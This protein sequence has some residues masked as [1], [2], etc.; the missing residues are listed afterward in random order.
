LR[1]ETDRHARAR[2]QGPDVEVHFLQGHQPRHGPDEHEKGVAAK[3]LDSLGALFQFVFVASAPFEHHFHYVPAQGARGEVSEHQDRDEL[4]CGA[5]THACRIHTRV[6][7]RS[8][9][10]GN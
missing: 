1:A 6:N 8:L 5:R 9:T 10:I 2:Q 4:H 3:I 7:A